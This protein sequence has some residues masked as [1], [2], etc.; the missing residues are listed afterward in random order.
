[1]LYYVRLDVNGHSNL[2]PTELT[3]YFIRTTR[4]LK[5]RKSRKE[6]AIVMEVVLGRRLLGNLLTI[7][8][9]TFLLNVIGHATNWFKSFFFEAVVTV[10]LTVLLV[11][12]TLFISV[13]ASLPTTSYVKMIDLWLIF[14]LLLPFVEVLI[15]T[16]KVT[17]STIMVLLRWWLIFDVLIS[18]FIAG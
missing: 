16:Y 8:I 18:R 5:M 6:D 12:V 13:S 2:G 17:R 3:Q 10:N 7:F 4:L 11:L 1:M 14:N 15:H 9:P